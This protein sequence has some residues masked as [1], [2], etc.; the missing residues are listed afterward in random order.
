MDPELLRPCRDILRVYSLNVRGC[1]ASDFNDFLLDAGDELGWSILSLQE[2]TASHHIERFS[3][4]AGH[5]VFLA[6]PCKGSRSCCIVI[7]ASIAFKV[8]PDSFRHRDRGV[9]VGLQWEGWNF[10]M[11]SAHLHPGHSRDI[12]TSSLDQTQDLCNIEHYRRLCA[13]SNAAGP[14]L[15][16]NPIYRVVGVDAQ[17]P[18][19]KPLST[20][21]ELIIGDATLGDRG[22]KGINF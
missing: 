1:K 7:H 11:V 4:T 15:S 2:F 22:W 8:I 17:T 13:L 18:I 10:L 16:N 5:R 6:A 19:G 12:Y 14:E 9:A 3:S 20:R 21:Q